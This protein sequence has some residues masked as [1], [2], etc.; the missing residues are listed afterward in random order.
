MSSQSP[1]MQAASMGQTLRIESLIEKG[2]N[3]NWQDAKGFSVL[4]AAINGN[5]FFFL[6]ISKHFNFFFFK[7]W[8]Y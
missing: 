7:R 1:L 4:H 3:V 5:V 2:E 6:L 8:L